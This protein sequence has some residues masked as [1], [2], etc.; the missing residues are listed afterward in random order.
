[1]YNI[2]EKSCFYIIDTFYHQSVFC[3]VLFIL[4][5]G[6]SRFFKGKSPHWLL[7]LWFLILLRLILPTDFSL[8]FSARN[9]ADD[10]L[11]A[12]NVNA[13][14]E[15]VSDRLSVK[16]R[17]IHTLDLR[18]PTPSAG[19]E[20]IGALSTAEFHEHQNMPLSWPVKL[21]I[22]WFCGALVFLILFLSKIRNIMTVLNHASLVRDKDTI[23]IVDY[24]RRSFNITRP[25]NIY[26]SDKFLSPFTTGLFRPKIFIPAPL[27]QGMDNETI[28]SIIAHEMV[29]I[30]H[31]DHAWIRL[32]NV[33]Q[34]I[35]FFNPIVW[36]V[37]SQ[38]NIERDRL[39]DSLVMARHVIPPKAFGKS[40][41][42]VL[43]YNLSGYRV[44]EPL[45]CFS[46]HKN[47]Y[48]YRLR[49]ILKGKT[50]SKPKSL[51]IFLLV[52][53]LG[54]FLLPMSNANI[55]S[56]KPEISEKIFSL[57]TEKIRAGTESDRIVDEVPE[58]DTT[59]LPGMNTGK[60]ENTGKKVENE[61]TSTQAAT[62]KKEESPMSASIDE[63]LDASEK[64]TRRTGK[65]EASSLNASEKT[66]DRNKASLQAVSK[67][68]KANLPVNRDQKNDVT[69]FEKQ[70]K[71]YEPVKQSANPTVDYFSRGMSYLK[72]G[73]VED[74]ISD[75]NKA[76]K[77]NPE[78]AVTYFSRGKAYFKKGDP[79]KAISDYDKAIELNP[80]YTD[81]YFSRGYYYQTIGEYGKAI[82]DYNKV[83]SI[84]PRNAHAYNYRGSAYFIKEEYQKAFTDFNKAIELN[85]GFAAAYQNRGSVYY[86]MGKQH[87]AIFDYNR[88]ITLNP[89]LAASYQ[90]R[91]S[92]YFN[93]D[94]FDEAISDYCK[95]LELNPEDPVTYN[96][97]GI[98]YFAREQYQKAFDDFNKVIELN[99]G[100]V[101][102]Y[103]Y[104]GYYHQMMRD[105]SKAIAD[106]SIALKLD[107]GI[108]AARK[109]LKE[110]AMISASIES[111]PIET[112]DDQ[113]LVCRWVVKGK[114][115]KKECRTEQEWARLR[116]TNK[117]ISETMQSLPPHAGENQ[118]LSPGLAMDI[119]YKR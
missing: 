99:P 76:I 43:K 61:E 101:D 12:H 45:L 13:S 91:G 58:G 93:Q 24:W 11:S 23:D 7:G 40:V 62:G 21:C 75:L 20:N 79:E 105:Y 6:L 51:A 17:P 109:L 71:S 119:Y 48:E 84:R 108:E 95:A 26:S 89:N 80:G 33:L 47:I 34:I 9:L 110:A 4:I 90:D 118:T 10:F 96:N 113:E 63:K 25:V 67:K 78:N 100:Y 114:A 112:A 60:E 59:S 50:I 15:E 87:K 53:L 65:M 52:F 56:K 35:Y 29:H 77:L 27:L 104:R 49:D 111:E 42:D 107:P 14:I 2:M 82:S 106:Y 66:V 19:E 18:S 73:E 97:R 54:L 32:Q 30:K 36:Y 102:P 41:I 8:S 31:F 38:I 69:I 1:M 88:S 116:K 98:A 86:R 70:K 115:R 64:Q 68:E 81:V 117:W 74:A 22:S 92:I 37:N 57:N 83:I 5:F 46:S 94:R 44:I 3:I 39:C 28:N 72:N 16:Y 103:I 55:D 85:P